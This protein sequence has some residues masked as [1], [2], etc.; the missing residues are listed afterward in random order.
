MKFKLPHYTTKD[1]VVMAWVMIPFSIILNSVIFGK[2]YY[3]GWSLFITATVIT[4]VA[5]C[6]DF[7]A[8]GAVAVAMKNR[9][10]DDRHVLK[11][12]S[13]M[14]GIF[15]ILSGIFL[16]VLFS[17]YER[18]HFHGYTFNE[19]GFIAAY[20]SMGTINIFLTFLHEGIS[21]FERWKANVKETEELKK[22]VLQS[23]LLG[24]KSQVNP[25]FLFNS[26]NSLSSL[27]NES[28]N[29]AE[30]FLDEMTKV[31]RYMLRNEELLV[32][33]EKELQFIRAYCALLKVRY[34]DAIQIQIDVEE[35]C[36]HLLLPPLSLQVIIENAFTQNMHSKSAPLKINVRSEHAALII[37]N[38]IQRK[39][40]TNAVDYEAGLDN[41]VSKYKLIGKQQLIIR[42]LKN[43]RIIQL[44]LLKKEA[45]IL[46]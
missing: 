28:P 17:G 44:P 23:K 24:L 46:V 31:Y 9:F 22:T 37:T 4:G 32:L 6:L 21:R 40:I 41:L 5:A 26:L 43:E 29:E 36:K 2:L 15:L 3:S 45:E 42:D 20:I 33:L 18:I 12:L 19:N 35:S 39:A 25:H 13:F 11:R 14:I 27:I 16:F 8:C 38:N 10:P 7:I 1:Y 34:G 30:R